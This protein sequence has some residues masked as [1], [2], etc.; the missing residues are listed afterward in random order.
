MKTPHLTIITGIGISVIIVATVL[1][2]FSPSNVTTRQNLIPPSQINPSVITLTV[3]G[4]NDTYLVGQRINFNINTTSTECS[5]PHVILTSENGSTIWTNRPDVMFCDII[6]SSWPAS[7]HWRLDNGDLGVLRVNQT[8]TYKMIISFF[9]KTIEREF[10]VISSSN[11]DCH[12]KGVSKNQDGSLVVLLMN[13]NSTA[14]ICTT[15]QFDSSWGSYQNK[16][17]YKGG[18]AHF[19]FSLGPKFNVTAIPSLLN[20]T[21]ASKGDTF[22]VMYKI[23]SATDSK[24]IYDYS[25]PWDTCEQYPLAVDYDVSKLKKSDFPLEVLL[26]RPCFNVIFHV[27]SNTIVSGMNFTEVIVKGQ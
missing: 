3:Y 27:T 25:I 24:G 21:N 19:G 4:L 14:T 1:I 6:S 18:M 10:S 11:L 5:R 13:P 23:S 8:G 9:G 22:S 16:A 15:Y 7:W 2:F 20:I 17:I 12:G 26:T